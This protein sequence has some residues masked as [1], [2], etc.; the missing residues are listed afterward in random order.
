MI[1]CLITPETM[2]AAKE[3]SRLRG[4]VDGHDLARVFAWMRPND[5]IWTYWVNPLT[6]ACTGRKR[7]DAVLIDGHSIGDS[8]LLPDH[9]RPRQL[10]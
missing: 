9:A 10:V 4:I 3:T 1:F 2:R 5:L 8:K 6:I 7:I